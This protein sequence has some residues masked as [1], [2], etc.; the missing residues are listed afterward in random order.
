MKKTKMT[1]KDA[2]RIQKANAKRNGGKVA[3]GSFAARAMK[4]AAKNTKK[5][6]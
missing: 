5:N 2:T 4:A 3:K 1:S 6:N